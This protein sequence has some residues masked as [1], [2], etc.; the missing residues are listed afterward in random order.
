MPGRPPAPA[1]FFVMFDRP[2]LEE[3]AAQPDT[4][5]NT[6]PPRNINKTGQRDG[7]MYV[8]GQGNKEAKVVFIAPG[9]LAEEAKDV[10]MS[11]TG[12]MIK[13]TPRY[14]KGAA[15]ITLVDAM[16]AA[17]IDMRNDVFYTAVCKWLLPKANRTKPTKEQIQ[18]GLPALETELRAIKPDIIVCLGKTAFDLVTNIRISLSDARGAWFYSEKYKAKVYLMEEVTKTCSRPE[19]VP[20]FVNDGEHIRRMMDKV[21]GIPVSEVE[22]HYEVIDS[23][24]ALQRWVNDMIASQYT[25]FSV[26]C[27]WGG[28]NHVDGQLRS[29]QF[30]WKPGYA[31]YLKFLDE[32][33]TYVFEGASYGEAGKVLSPLLDNKNVKY[34][35][36]HISADLPWLH[37]WLGLEWYEKTLLDTEFAQQSVDEYESLSLESFSL[38]YT[39]LGR[40]DMELLLWKKANKLTAGE[41]YIRIPDS[42]IIPYALKDVDVVIRS[43]PILLKK[44]MDEQ[45]TKYYFE[46]LNPFVTDVFTSFALTGLPMDVARMDQ[47]R[48]LYTFCRDKLNIQL[49]RDVYEEAKGL[50]V[51]ELIKTGMSAHEIMRINAAVRGAV[52]LVE[53]QGSVAQAWDLVK[54]LVEPAGILK[55]KTIFD[56]MVDARAFN[57][58]STPH[59]KRWLFDVKGFRPVKS[60]ANRANGMPSLA[61]EKVEHLPIRLRGNYQPAVDRQSLEILAD[62]YNYDLLHKLIRLNAIGNI[63]KNFL[64]EPDVDEEGNVTKE[65]GLHFYLCSDGRV[66]GQMSC[67]ETGRPRSWKPNSLNWPKHVTDSIEHGVREVIATL[68]PEEL[69]WLQSNTGRSISLENNIPSVR[70]CVSA[71]PGWCF[72]ESDYKTAE[73]RGLAFISGDDKLIKIITQPDAQ[74]GLDKNTKKPLRLSYSDDCGIPEDARDA[75]L[76]VSPEDSKLIRDAKGGLSHPPTDLHWSLAEMMYGTP[77]EKLEDNKHRLA[78]KIGNFQSMYGATASTLERKIEQDSGHKPDEGTGVRILGALERRQPVATQFLKSLERVPTY[79]GYLRAASGRVRH[80]ATHYSKGAR[81]ANTRAE[82]RLN[83]ALGR[84]ARNYFMQES[85]AATSA[86]AGKWLLGYFLKRGMQARPMIILYDSVV[87]LCPMEERFEVAK[88]HQRFMTDENTWEYYGDTMNYP[89]DSDFV[90][91]WTAKPTKEEKE[92]LYK[93]VI[94]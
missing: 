93:E 78:A 26:D 36:H 21:C 72:V 38:R 73:I 23:I 68:T 13:S 9:L 12:Q 1:L 82:E 25:I 57:L 59:M 10:A 30:A 91:R 47:L 18:W 63:C 64:K 85:V 5:G 90:F 87:T 94:E 3:E 79:P 84:E 56:H 52:L 43:F 83:N 29:V 66:H 4:T 50:M 42:I 71:P 35:G 61:W 45:L 49:Q 24:T 89:I 14:L 67:T 41:G 28:M 74:F 34:V 58:R 19:L 33:G 20:V 16:Q 27:E 31:V 51:E 7:V 86:R 92:I 15:G 88:L 75:T 46:I 62:T 53:E 17:G 55:A 77:R 6:A 80:F 39:D 60:T 81:A 37:T 76:V 40:Y 69:A 11:V 48:V 70:S 2:Q 32:T 54:P 8:A 22:Q 65:N 44:L